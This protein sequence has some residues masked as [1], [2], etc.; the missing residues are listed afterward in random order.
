MK[1]A[2][3]DDDP[4]DRDEIYRI[5]NEYHTDTQLTIRCFSS[6]LALY[7]E[8]L[9]S[10]FDVIF[11]DIIMPEING[12][13]LAKKILATSGNPLIIFLT[14]SMDYVISGYEVAFRYVPKP[15]SSDIIYKVLDAAIAKLQ[16]H[17]FILNCENQTTVFQT[18]DIYYFES[19]NH[20]TILH[21][22]DDSFAFRDSLKQ[23]ILHLPSG[24]F[25]Q[26]H[27]SYIVNMDQVIS[28]DSKNV[29]LANGEKIPLSRRQAGEFQTI[30]NY[31]LES[32]DE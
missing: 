6:P 3:C 20:H 22:K 10:S 2:I 31:Y 18:K 25:F 4:V 21:T 19:I 14:T 5:V 8:Q 12:F 15:A 29:I 27:K 1:I 17:R 9:E 11:L 23:V 30:F 16:P 32:E 28:C 24:K 7:N 26:I 13:Q